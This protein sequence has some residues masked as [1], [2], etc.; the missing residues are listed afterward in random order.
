M[1]I[2]ITDEQ[3]ERAGRYIH[4]TGDNDIDDITIQQLEL[5]RQ[6]VASGV[7][8]D[9]VKPLLPEAFKT[10]LQWQIDGRNL[11]SF[12][13]LRSSKEALWEIRLLARAIFDNLPDTHKYL[14][15]ECMKDVS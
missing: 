11:Q 15:E 8:N 2:K 14:Y 3:R 7:S 12:L 1:Q 4:L 6:K 9:K 10:R 13:E 5:L